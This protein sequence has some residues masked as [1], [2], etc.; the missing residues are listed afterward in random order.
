V[1]KSGDV[2][3]VEDSKGRLPTPMLEYKIKPITK[4][5]GEM[6]PRHKRK[7]SPFSATW[8]ATLELLE[9]ELN[10]LRGSNVIIQMAYREKDLTFDGG[11]RASARPVDHPGIILTFNSKHGP[12]S[13][14]TDQYIDWEANVRAVA[15][16]LKALRQI[17]RYGVSKQGTQ[18]AGYK[19]LGAAPSNRHKELT[20]AEAAAFLCDHTGIPTDALLGVPA[21]FELAYRDA[22]KKLHPDVGGSHELFIRLTE[23]AAVLKR[24]HHK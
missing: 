16:A 12:L 15:F 24:R 18:Y 11:I 21:I 5:P 10:Y 19:Q 7:R 14:W 23:A 20:E 13:Y 3:P 1:S 6:T 2:K 22:Q 17:D 9:T 4:W 8:G